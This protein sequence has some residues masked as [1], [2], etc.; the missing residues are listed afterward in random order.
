MAGAQTEKAAATVRESSRAGGRDMTAGRGLVAA[1]SRDSRT[2]TKTKE[3]PAMNLE[4]LEKRVRR[5]EDIEAIRDL[6]ARYCRY[7]DDGYDPDGIAGLFVED[8]VWDGGPLGRCE[9]R[10]AIRKFFRGASRRVSFAIH[11]VMN[12]RITVD[13]DRATGA[14]Y[15]FQPCTF[16][17]GDRAMWMAAR[18]ADEYVRVGGEWKFEKVSVDL[19]FV[20]PYDEGWAKTRFA[21]P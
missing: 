4:E 2:T 14:W 21:Q 1:A 16:V 8:G 12:P 3:V 19:S 11:H 18:Y 7:C 17:E 5:L 9:G 13:G 10:E 6:K 20:T 15:L